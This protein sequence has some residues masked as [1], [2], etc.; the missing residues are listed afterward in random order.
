MDIFRSLLGN[1]SQKA[2]IETARRNAEQRALEQRA[3]VINAIEKQ[4]FTDMMDPCHHGFS[5]EKIY[6]YEPYPVVIAPA[7]LTN[8]ALKY[9][10]PRYNSETDTVDDGNGVGIGSL[11]FFGPGD[12][13]TNYFPSGFDANGREITIAKYKVGVGSDYYFDKPSYARGDVFSS[14]FRGYIRFRGFGA[15]ADAPGQPNTTSNTGYLTGGTIQFRV[16]DS[17]DQVEEV[18][19]ECS[20]EKF[21]AA[22]KER[23]AFP[24]GVSIDLDKVLYP[25]WTKPVLLTAGSTLEVVLKLAPAAQILMQTYDNGDRKMFSPVHG[26]VLVDGINSSIDI[27]THRLIYVHGHN[28]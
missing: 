9:G 15:G 6:G 19:L 2:T 23:G 12:V 7:T 11:Q 22:S 20:L 8:N 16:V 10:P 21:N 13:K 14:R 26:Y 27:E 24:P 5:W 4:F 25:N 28:L 1:Q 3:L 18:I 17:A